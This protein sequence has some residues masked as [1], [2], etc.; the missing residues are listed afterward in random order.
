MVREGVALVLAALAPVREVL[1]LTVL[2]MPR[3]GREEE[4]VV[5]DSLPHPT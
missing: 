4:V 2:G 3:T 5:A 1:A